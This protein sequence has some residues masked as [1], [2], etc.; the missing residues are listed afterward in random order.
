MGS[1]KK[2]KLRAVKDEEERQ[3]RLDDMYD[4]RERFN[5]MSDEERKD[6]QTAR[7]I[8]R[9]VS[10]L[11]KDTYNKKPL[12]SVRGI[13][14]SRGCSPSGPNNGILCLCCI[15]RGPFNRI[16]DGPYIRRYKCLQC[17]STSNIFLSSMAELPRRRKSKRHWK[18]FLNRD[19]FYR[20]DGE[21][22]DLMK[23]KD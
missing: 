22:V 21:P 11:R 2:R 18:R 4:E 9:M 7:Q 13:R 17:G 5:A 1:R 8:E 10:V 23:E 19:V 15:R 20:F 3:K 6:K 12:K 16:E 14:Q